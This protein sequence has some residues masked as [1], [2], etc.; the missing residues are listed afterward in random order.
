MTRIHYAA[1]V[2][3]AC[4]ISS[5]LVAQASLQNYYQGKDL[6][7]QNHATTLQQ[8]DPRA[9]CKAVGALQDHVAHYEGLKYVPEGLEEHRADYMALRQ[10]VSFSARACAQ[11]GYT[12]M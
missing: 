10:F 7:M 4:A 11:A 2:F 8:N 1:L 12:T 5:P 3:A 6:L 9:T